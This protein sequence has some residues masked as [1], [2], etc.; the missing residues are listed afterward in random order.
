MPRRPLAVSTQTRIRMLSPGVAGQLSTFHWRYRF[1][2]VGCLMRNDDQ[3]P[4]GTEPPIIPQAPITRHRVYTGTRET[5]S[6]NHHAQIAKFRGTYFLAWS[7]GY[8]DEEAGGQR[9]LIARS[10]DGCHWSEPVCV[11]GRGPGE[12]DVAHNSV[13]LYAADRLYLFDMNEDTIRDATAVGMRRIDPLSTRIDV[14]ASEDGISWQKVHTMSSDIR[15]IFEAPRPT[16]EGRLMVVGNLRE[17]G[18]AIL[19]WPGM[20]ILQTP[21]YIPVP[22]PEGAKFPY[23]ES[24]WYQADDGRIFVFWRDE[25]ASCRLYVSVSDD[26]GHSFTPPMFSDIPD[27]MSRN[28]AGRLADGR[29]FLCNNAVPT[30]LDRRHLMLHLSRDGYEFDTVYIL[31]ND[32]TSQRRKGLLKEDGYQ[33]PCCLP[34]EG[35][36]LVA[37]SVNKEDIE[38][39]IVDT[40]GI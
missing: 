28:F 15:W 21:E 9:I 35:R 31:L 38:C 27:S 36:L 39:G 24:S 23:G 33:Y 13:A 16:R 12:E 29:Y 22:E 34:E 2:D 37:Y 3:G 10:E 25:G 8:V 7:N 5:G 6:F 18:P 17:K 20:D 32:P 30:L 19:L 11:A 4:R 26:N 40:A 1:Q 14:Y